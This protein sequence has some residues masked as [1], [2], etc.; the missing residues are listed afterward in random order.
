MGMPPAK[1]KGAAGIPLLLS[2]DDDFKF[3]IYIKQ[4]FILLIYLK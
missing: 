3:M 1:P 4:N 2:E